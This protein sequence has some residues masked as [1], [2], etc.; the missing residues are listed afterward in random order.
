MFR[1]LDEKRKKTMKKHLFTLFMSASILFVTGCGSA[2]S[3]NS[4]NSNDSTTDDSNEVT[5]Y[6]VR[7]GETMLNETDRVQG[8]ADAVL[9]PDGEKNV[10]DA[11][12]GLADIEFSAAYSSD[13]GRSI[14]TANAIL[15]ENENSSDISLETDQRL[16]EFNFGSYEGALNETMWTDIAESQGETLDEWRSKGA[17]PEEFANSVAELDEENTHEDTNWPAEDYDTISQRLEE[18]VDD[19]SQRV[20]EDGGGNVLIVSHGLSIG[21]MIENVQSGYTLPEGGLDNASLTTILY[22]N[23]Q[24]EIEEVGDTNYIEKGQ[25]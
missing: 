20:S 7:H 18:G 13:S 1:N 3:N 4:A 23:N 6:I 11:G 5:L 10:S 12:E 17:S 22:N 19:I 21:A 9:T 14:Q 2:S 15:E 16:R 25:E 8:W 24:Y